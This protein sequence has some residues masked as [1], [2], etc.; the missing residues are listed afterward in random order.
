MMVLLL[1]WEVELLSQVNVPEEK[2]SRYTIS[3]QISSR[4]FSAKR[5]DDLRCET[6]SFSEEVPRFNPIVGNMGAACFQR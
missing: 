2:S 5:A 1:F 3:G 6:G 4:K